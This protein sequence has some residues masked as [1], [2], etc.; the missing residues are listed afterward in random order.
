MPAVQVHE[1]K[2]LRIFWEEEEKEGI[3]GIDWKDSTSAM[4]GSNSKRN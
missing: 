2:F 1:D 3:I 4:T